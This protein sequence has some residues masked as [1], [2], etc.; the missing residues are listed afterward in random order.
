MSAPWYLP[1]ARRADTDAPA[2]PLLAGASGLLFAATLL[3][4]TAGV[5]I[6][7]LQRRNADGSVQEVRVSGDLLR[8][9]QVWQ[10]DAPRQKRPEA[11][12]AGQAQ[13]RLAWLPEGL[14]L[15]PRS[16]AAPQG[17]GLP[18]RD[19]G[20]YT[21]GGP[22]RQ[23]LLNTKRGNQ[24]PEV[25]HGWLD[26]RIFSFPPEQRKVE[27]APLFHMPWERVELNRHEMDRG[28]GGKSLGGQWRA[29][30]DA[31][32]L[33]QWQEADAPQG[34]WFA[35]R[36][37]VVGESAFQQAAR[38]ITNEL[39]AQKGKLPL[40]APLRG[41]A[42]TL[43][44]VALY[45][46][47]DSQ[48]FGHDSPRFPEGYQSL[49]MRVWHRLTRGV[50]YGE[51]LAF[52]R[53][54]ARDEE[55]AVAA[56]EQWRL[57]PRHYANIIKD[58]HAGDTER[59][60]WVEH[61]YKAGMTFAWNQQPPYGLGAPVQPIHPPV[62]G[63]EA[64][65]QH[66]LATSEWV[67]FGLVGDDLPPD[68][69]VGLRNFGL[70]SGGFIEPLFYDRQ[71][72]IDAGGVRQVLLQVTHRGRT[73]NVH[74]QAGDEQMVAVL[75]AGIQRTAQG[76]RLRVA[77]LER[78]VTSNWQQAPRAQVALYEGALHDFEAT[79][80]RLGVFE[81]PERVGHMSAVKFSSTGQAVFCFTMNAPHMWASPR[82]DM[83]NPNIPDRLDDW[84]DV[85]ANEPW[86]WDAPYRRFWGGQVHFRLWQDGAGWQTP[87][88]PQGV[89][90]HSQYPLDEFIETCQGEYA[91]LAD[92]GGP[93]R[94]QL[95]FL[96]VRVDARIHQTEKQGQ[97]PT[98]DKRLQGWL[99][100]PDGQEFQYQDVT[101]RYGTAQPEGVSGFVFHLGYVNVNRPEC[102]S[103]LR[104]KL[105]GSRYARVEAVVEVC[106]HEVRRRLALRQTQQTWIDAALPSEHDALAGLTPWDVRGGRLTGGADRSP[107]KMKPFYW[108][109]HP[110]T[111]THYELAFEAGYQADVRRS[112]AAR[113]AMPFV[114]TMERER[115]A[116]PWGNDTFSYEVDE[117]GPAFMGSGSLGKAQMQV[118]FHRGQWLMQAHVDD[119]LRSR[120]QWWPAQECVFH[121]SS[122]PLQGLIGEALLPDIG[123]IGVV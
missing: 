87:I 55:R 50:S 88:A 73:I 46:M 110:R 26:P 122:L 98:L 49:E 116:Y 93:G 53:P 92:F 12:P 66:F 39:R 61:A 48:V 100:F 3:A 83:P 113:Q 7:R 84:E 77:V 99:V 52:D 97:E 104:L 5:P 86:P 18:M 38:R 75:G 114:V 59:Y 13:A 9:V 117:V 109:A 47:A 63:R 16:A 27:A 20:S 105:S 90:V 31:Q 54:Y 76:A 11:V 43:G 79:R 94:D 101:A 51:N 119:P 107:S 111:P 56:L 82:Y 15:T 25:L 30:F 121:A 60:V 2:A 6:V 41:W 1:F 70:T 17:R 23:V 34:Q 62:T 91:L 85:P 65:T 118:E 71:R 78:E 32:G 74:R 24:Y 64:L 108:L 80:Q 68:E 67:H 106:G 28:I 89:Q 33:P 115:Y 19:D 81:L 10:R 42:G 29:Q 40:G 123:P 44:P 103:G 4:Q 69:R 102:T 120:G 57:S 14:V 45:A 72:E 21:P 35:H 112:L 8:A 22:L 58:W 95:R 96:R 36:P 37:Q